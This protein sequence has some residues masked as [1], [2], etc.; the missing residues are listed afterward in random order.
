MSITKKHKVKSLGRYE[1]SVSEMYG[2]DDLSACPLFEGNYINWGYY[3]FLENRLK[4]KLEI[5]DRIAASE[6]LYEVCTNLL[7][8]NKK[9]YL[10]EVCCGKAEGLAFIYRKYSMQHI[11]ALDQN[12]SYL[13]YAKNKLKSATFFKK[14]AE[15]FN[16]NFSFDKILCIEAAQHFTNFESFVSSSYRALKENGVLVCAMV[17]GKNIRATQE[18]GDSIQTVKDGID[19]IRN[20]EEVKNLF[21]KHGFKCELIP[22]GK[23]VFPGFDKWASQT[24]LK[25]HWTRNWIQAYRQGLIDYYIIKAVKNEDSKSNICELHEAYQ[26]GILEK[27]DY[28]RKAHRINKSLSSISK[29]LKSTDIESIE[30]KNNEILFT[31]RREKIKLYFNSVDRRGAPFEILNFG[32]YEATENDLLFKLIKDGDVLF[33]VGANIGWYSLLFSKRFKKSLIYS[34]EPI[35]ENFSFLKKNIIKNRSKNI[36]A[37]NLALGSQNGKVDFYYFPE[38]SILSSEKNLLSCPK[39]TKIVCNMQTLDSF[40]L[41]NQVNRIDFIKCDIEGGELNFIKSAKNTIDTFKPILL[42]E[43]CHRWDKE[44]NYHPN[45][46]IREMSFLDYLCFGVDE[47]KLTRIY[48]LDSEPKEEKLNYFF[49]NEDSHKALIS[50]FEKNSDKASER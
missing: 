23:N 49:L 10:L 47:G 9:D 5:K 15:E 29:R 16:F 11:Y 17:L 39:A 42:V 1:K 28:I 33:D 43:L 7:N 22:I 37:F 50:K 36:T 20:Y 13:T 32:N 3:D 2:E 40:V 35:P 24:Y 8:L 25:N 14:N 19:K 31:T 48:D 26:K 21:T 12:Q 34:F 38:A 4:K 18:I 44:F 46:I 41:F 45:D 30:I 6:R 27:Y